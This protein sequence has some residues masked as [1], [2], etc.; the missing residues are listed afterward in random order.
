MTSLQLVGFEDSYR[1]VPWPSRL[2]HGSM[3]LLA[4]GSPSSPERVDGK[5]TNS[6]SVKVLILA[7]PDAALA[8]LC[9]S[10]SA[11]CATEPTPAR[12]ER[13][14]SSRIC[15]THPRHRHPADM[16]VPERTTNPF[17]AEPWTF[18]S[19][20][21]RHSPPRPQAR[22]PTKEGVVGF[23][24]SPHLHVPPHGPMG[25]HSIA[26]PGCFAVCPE[27]RDLPRRRDTH[28]R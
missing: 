20:P 11:Y 13:T 4:K 3:A 5:L 23:D 18:P 9:V 16:A 26:P 10:T 1:Q 14:A 7:A 2:H 6:S 19:A 15:T 22:H 24:R 27:W 25:A 17:D 21:P 28:P 12:K 8:P